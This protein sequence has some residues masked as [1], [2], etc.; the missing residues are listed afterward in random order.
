MVIFGLTVVIALLS[1]RRIESSNFESQKVQK[2]HKLS[3]S[4][5]K[6]IKKEENKHI[7]SFSIQ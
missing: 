4:Q 3:T 2:T 1:K 7:F 5:C 6:L